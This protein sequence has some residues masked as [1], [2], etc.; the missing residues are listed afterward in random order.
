M[1]YKEIEAKA[2]IA[3]A[4]VY[5]IDPTARKEYT[6]DKF[7]KKYINGFHLDDV[8]GICDKIGNELKKAGR[9]AEAKTAHE[10]PLFVFSML[11]HDDVLRF[12]REWR[13]E[14]V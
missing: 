13:A 1:T 8:R 4:L 14:N 9:V 6:F 12:I 11:K 10:I 3:E 7:G 2:Q 5:T